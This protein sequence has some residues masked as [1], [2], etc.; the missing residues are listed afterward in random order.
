MFNNRRLLA[1]LLGAALFAAGPA[2]VSADEILARG[3]FTGAG[4]H[5]T[6]GP[7]SIV[8]TANG[9][10]VRLGANFSVDRG[11]SLQLGFGSNGKYDD[12]SQFSRLG[13]N[14]GAQVYKLP[15]RID[16]SKYNELYV[17]CSP[18]RVP[19][20]VARLK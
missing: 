17:W 2:A 3:T 1:T 20:G 7:V 6:S 4:G 18:F 15:A 5:Q 14:S 19:F 13:K 8:K 16:V 11:P 9:V 12:N 10:E